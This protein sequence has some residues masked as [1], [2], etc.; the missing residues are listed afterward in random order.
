MRR[1]LSVIFAC[2]L[3]SFANA[4]EIKIGAIIER[5]DVS[6]N[7]VSQSVGTYKVNMRVCV[8][9]KDAADEAMFLAYQ[10]GFKTLSSFSGTLES[11]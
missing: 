2:F 5:Y 9:S 8:M 7:M 6:F 1:I 3:V 4:Q 11:G 10:D